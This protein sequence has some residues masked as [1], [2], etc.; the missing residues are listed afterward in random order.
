MLLIQYD[1][2]L[3]TEV[4]LAC[5]QIRDWDCTEK[6]ETLLKMQID[7][8]IATICDIVLHTLNSDQSNM[9]L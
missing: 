8:S 2:I 7:A 1:S 5:D 9:S 6:I 4:S 3:S